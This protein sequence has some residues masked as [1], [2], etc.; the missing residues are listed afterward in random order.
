[1]MDVNGFKTTRRQSLMTFKEILSGPGAFP[2]GI[3]VIICSTSSCV[4][5]LLINC[6]LRGIVLGTNGIEFLSLH[7]F[8]SLCFV[9]LRGC[10][11]VRG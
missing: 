4:A 5:S 1:M 6:S 11:Y 9:Q 3:L 2:K 10:C 7:E 8:F